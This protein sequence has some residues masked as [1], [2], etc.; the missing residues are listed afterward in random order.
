MFWIWASTMI[1]LLVLSQ[2]HPALNIPLE[3]PWVRHS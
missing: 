3:S 1:I 2:P